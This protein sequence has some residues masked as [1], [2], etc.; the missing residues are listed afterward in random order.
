M[1]KR[2]LAILVVVILVLASAFAG[3]AK[4]T[5]QDTTDKPVKTEG[6]EGNEES[7]GPIQLTGLTITQSSETTFPYPVVNKMAEE[8][9]L[10]ITWETY[11]ITDW[12][13]Q[14][15]VMLAGGDLP[16]IWYSV[17]VTDADANSGLFTDLAPYIDSTV[18]IKRFFTEIPE[19]RTFCTNPEGTIY[20]L[21][22]QHALKPIAGDS[23]YVNKTWCDTLGIE[24]PKTLDDYADMLR[25]FVT[26]DPNGDG[27]LNEIG[28]TGYGVLP[29]YTPGDQINS[30]GAVQCFLPSFGVVLSQGMA[31]RPL[32]MVVDGE[33]VFAP[34]MEG[35]KEALIWLNGLYSEGLIDQELFTMDPPAMMAKLGASEGV[36]AGAGSAWSKE[37]FCLGEA[38][39]FE[40]IAP[41]IGPDGQQYWRSDYAFSMFGNT[42]MIAATCE[43]TEAVMAF[44]DLCYDEWNSLQI[45][46]GSEGVGTAIGDDGNPMLIA[47]P[48]G[49]TGDAFRFT[50][51]SEMGPGWASAEYSASVGGRGNSD[52]F[53]KGDASAFYSDYFLPESRY[54]TV[55]WTVEQTER[56]STLQT[57]INTYADTALVDFI[58]NGG[59][60][61]GWQDYLDKLDKMGLPEL[62]EIYVQG[63]ESTK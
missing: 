10:E 6:S 51:A 11:G 26:Q 3:C 42:A 2:Y 45:A 62:M 35:F 46:Y 13:T 21:P 19:A 39:N 18:N 41:P 29:F 37:A 15:S 56:L 52:T 44:Y 28:Y 36:M 1:K 47:A 53:L 43:E 5:D 33:V 16:D 9:N 48:D 58:M 24:L 54:P 27:E 59:V 34:T 23:M 31:P 17:T 4:T 50:C 57:D 49:S 30:M 12:G 25:A 22:S 61:E 20:G 14:K 7:S 40:Y 55:K 8:A 32:T 60:E 38:D 63:Y